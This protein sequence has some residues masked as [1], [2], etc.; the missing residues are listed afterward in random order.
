MPIWLTLCDSL[1]GTLVPSWRATLTS[2]LA[3]LP[4]TILDPVNK[5]WDGSWKE[6]ASFQP[7]KTQVEWELEG[8]ERA[9]IVV[10]YFGKQE[11][12]PI[13]MMELG[14]SIGRQKRVIVGCEDGFYKKGNI[15]I[16]CQRAN[17]D[18][19]SGVEEV[20]KT[21]VGILNA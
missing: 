21:V 17:V 16:V 12:A 3:H 19:L 5:N 7:F 2:A 6:S 14:L 8:L 4:V 10:V 20:I 9:D 15:D 13:T 11:K 18:V 1:S